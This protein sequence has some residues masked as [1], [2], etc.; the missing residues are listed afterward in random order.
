MRLFD[1]EGYL[2]K[3]KQWSGPGRISLAIEHDQLE[4]SD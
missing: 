2:A 3:Q 1:V 4:E